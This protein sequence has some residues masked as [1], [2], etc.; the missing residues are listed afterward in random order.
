MKDSAFDSSED[1]PRAQNAVNP[2]S[3]NGSRPLKQYGIC[4]NFK[5]DP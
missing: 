3:Q 4:F 2:T 1:G 5:Q